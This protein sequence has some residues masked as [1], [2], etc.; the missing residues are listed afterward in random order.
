MRPATAA[1][2]H[3]M[4]CLAVSAH[5]GPDQGWRQADRV[6]SSKLPLDVHGVSPT[7]VLAWL[8][9]KATPNSVIEIAVDAAPGGG[10]S[11]YLPGL[12]LTRVILRYDDSVGYYLGALHIPASAPSKGSCTVRVEDATGHL[13]DFRVTLSGAD[14]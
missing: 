9:T 3:L 7:E 13:W 8:P 4:L 1:F 2:T 6:Q 12:D 14:G 11:V 5:A 10:L